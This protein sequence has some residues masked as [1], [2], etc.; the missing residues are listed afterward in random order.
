M[1]KKIEEE[2]LK[3]IEERAEKHREMMEREREQRQKR[4]ASWNAFKQKEKK[5]KY[6]HQEIEERYTKEIVMPQLEKKKKE[7]ENIR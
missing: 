1:Q 4:D 6:V 3:R 5:S 2:R 7:L